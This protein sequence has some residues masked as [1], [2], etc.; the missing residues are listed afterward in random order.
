MSGLNL[1]FVNA[2]I[3][4]DLNTVKKCYENDVDIFEEEYES[5]STA[6]EYGHLHLVKYFLDLGYDIDYEEGY[7]I[8][9][10]C[11]RGK[12][13]IVKYLVSRGANINLDDDL[14][15]CWA[16]SNGHLEVAKYLFELGV[17]IRA[18]NGDA[19]ELAIEDSHVNIVRFLV[20]HGMK[21]AFNDLISAAKKNCLE[22]VKIGVEQDELDPFII[23]VA[24]NK[25][26]IFSLKIAL[27][28]RACQYGHFDIVK[29]LVQKGAKID[30]IYA[31]NTFYDGYVSVACYLEQFIN[32]TYEYQHDDFIPFYV[33]ITTFYNQEKW[34][35]IENV[36]ENY[37]F[38]PNLSLIIASFLW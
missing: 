33:F 26:E 29:Y 37:L 30:V 11:N 16:C 7:P 8:Q 18:Q 23:S 4:G 1:E 2:C 22:I 28:K 34:N 27:L 5:L 14:A 32:P 15:F 31:N 3:N 12:L 20:E 21:I 19:M 24:A 6:C 38:D 9:I 35:K 25:Q 10:A 17:N 36:K 13:E